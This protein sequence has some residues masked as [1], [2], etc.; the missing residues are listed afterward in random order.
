M[1]SSEALAHNYFAHLGFSRIDYEPEGSSRPPD[2]LLDSRIAVE[3]RRLNQ[4]ETHSQAIG[5]PRGLEEISNPSGT[6]FG[7]CFPRWVRQ[8]R[9]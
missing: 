3:V 6:L 2:F 1:D 8:P 4:I 7:M 9:M 5:E